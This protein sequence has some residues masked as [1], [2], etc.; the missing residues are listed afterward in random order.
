MVRV[1]YICTVCIG[2]AST[3]KERVESM[4]NITFNHDIEKLKTSA[5]VDLMDRVAQMRANG[6]RVV[7]L[8]VGEPDFNTPSAVSLAGIREIT[9]GNTH[10]TTSRGIVPLR[11]RIARKLEQ[12]NDIPC[13][14]K[15]VLVTPGGKISIYLAVRTMVNP[16]DEVMILD[17]SWVS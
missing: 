1:S 16:G 3:I 5:S 14:V 8:S 15:N 11:K 12:E 2:L 10:Y 7:N 13:G 6:E 9:K 4:K 17:P